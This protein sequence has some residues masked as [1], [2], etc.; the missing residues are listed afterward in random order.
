MKNPMVVPPQQPQMAGIPGIEW[1]PSEAAAVNEF[2]N[3][4]VGRKWLGILLIRKPKIILEG[5]EKAALS[6][7]Y[8]AGY[9]SFFSEVA[10]TRIG[11]MPT[12]SAG[13]KS[14]YVT[15]D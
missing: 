2:L 1:S 10:N 12:E 7:A 6:G 15:K 8:A 13:L 14:I 4:P 11:R 5:T 3:S 9:E